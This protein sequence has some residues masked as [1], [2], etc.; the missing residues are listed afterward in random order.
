MLLLAGQAAQTPE[1]GAVLIIVGT[2]LVLIAALWF[3]AAVSKRNEV[4]EMSQAFNAWAL[5]A[6]SVGGLF[7]LIG[8]IETLDTHHTLFNIAAY[9]SLTAVFVAV[10]ISFRAPRVPGSKVRDH[11]LSVQ[12]SPSSQHEHERKG[13]NI[14]P[15]NIKSDVTEDTKSNEITNA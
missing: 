14:T 4:A 5:G 1:W 3:M 8:T 15:N 9:V 11:K 12:E 10:C 2:S 13:K 6:G 7:L